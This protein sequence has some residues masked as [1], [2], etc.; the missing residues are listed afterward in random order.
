MNQEEIRFLYSELKGYLGQLPIPKDPHENMFDE[1]SWNQYNEAVNE[2]NRATGKNYNK[3]LINPS[4]DH[5]NLTTFRQKI[6]GLILRLHAEYFS[7]EPEPFS[8][9]PGIVISQ[10]QQQTQSVFFQMI[11]EL[12]DKI[13]EKISQSKDGS[14]EKGFLQK[15]RPVVRTAQ[16][17]TGLL[18]QLLTLADQ[19]GIDTETL[20]RIFS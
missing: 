10:N 19:C 6:H 9:G 5:V 1:D 16:N 14:K 3:F 17:I 13:D 7:D 20:K 4:E 15:L 12:Q 8:G 18:A 11:F 2:L